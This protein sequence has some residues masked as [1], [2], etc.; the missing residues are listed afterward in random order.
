MKFKK[1][2]ILNRMHKEA[3]IQWD[4]PIAESL[5]T[6]DPIVSLLFNSV[7]HELE[8]IAHEISDSNERIFEKIAEII[9]PEVYTTALP[10]HAVLHA[11]PI[12]KSSFVN[13]SK[14]FYFEKADTQAGSSSQPKLQQIFFSPLADYLIQKVEVR[15]F[16]SRNLINQYTDSPNPAQFS[17][18]VSDKKLPAN[19]FWLGLEYSPEIDNIE[20][21]A[22]FFNFNNVS[23]ENAFNYF[24]HK[25]DCSLNDI[26]LKFSLGLQNRSEENNIISTLNNKTK[27]F[28]AQIKEYYNNK[29][30]TLNT[31]INTGD[32]RLHEKYPG[33]FSEVFD[34]KQ[35]EKIEE[36]L[37]WLK[38]ES[39]DIL[40]YDIIEKVIC[41]TNCFPIINRRLNESHHII[42]KLNNIV[43]LYTE[44][45]FWDVHEVS[46]TGGRKIIA[47]DQQNEN[48]DI[49]AVLR[50]SGVKRIDQRTASVYLNKIRNLIQ[51]EKAAFSFVGQELLSSKLTE[52][53][54]VL[55]NLEQYTDKHNYINEEIPY[56]MFFGE[57]NSLSLFIKFWS[58][59]GEIA[60]RIASGTPLQLY[61]GSE[62]DPASIFLA[63]MSVAGRNN[64]DTEDK[65]RAFKHSLLTRDRIISKEDIRAF[66][67]Y[68]LGNKLLN[69][70]IRNGVGTTTSSKTGLFRTTDLIIIIDE[71]YFEE[72]PRNELEKIFKD[73][74]IELIQ[75]SN[76]AFP[77]RIHI[78]K[79]I[80]LEV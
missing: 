23:L 45:Y 78:N 58:T 4:F 79:D 16:V 36:N 15:Y 43:P 35:L 5:N 9:T 62:I 25:A 13:K 66:F 27:R 30:I 57:F 40:H 48:Y 8:Q 37:L 42:S 46:D 29:F 7:A 67:Q 65:I 32:F 38:F 77:Y 73:F 64:L 1:K 28:E 70:E 47:G 53:N 21:L 2:D 33:E 14:Q 60:N 6:F 12:E 49:Q 3:S 68:K 69:F 19:I 54:Q 18:S 26:V 50:K 39:K 44:E 55:A 75:K 41:S 63:T 71:E 80:I 72:T 61:E 11:S 59:N 22:I 31:N 10:A 34:L 52:L 17:K 51:E 24:L 74:L 20:D 76:N 56:L